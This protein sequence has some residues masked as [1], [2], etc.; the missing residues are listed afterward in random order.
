MKKH[1]L[2]III[3][4]IKLTVNSQTIEITGSIADSSSK[5]LLS[6]GNVI[7]KNKADSVIR[8]SLTNENGEFKIKNIKYQEGQYLLVKY[9]GFTD[10]KVEINYTNNSKINI[11][12]IFIQPDINMMK[13]AVVIDKAKYMEQQFDRKV[14]NIN[15]AKTTSAKNIFDLLRTLPGVTVELNDNVK[16][17]GAPATI[18]VDDQPAEYVY[19]KTEMIPVASVL[20][21]EVIDA[22]LRS[23]EGKGGIINI[24]MKNQTTDGFSGVAQTNNSTIKFNKINESEDYIN[25][26]YKV[27][28]IL[29]YYNAN[30]NHS[31]SYS[32][33]KTDGTLS[34]GSN[35]YQLNDES[36]NES[37]SDALWNYGGFRISPNANTRFRL[38]GGFYKNKGT[39]LSNGNSQ[40]INTGTNTI[41]DKYNAN[42]E[43]TNN[44][45]SK[46][47]NASF[48]HRIDTIGKEIS[49]YGGLQ[50]QGN[51]NKSF[52]TY[53][54]EMPVVSSENYKTENDWGQL[55][56]YGGLFHNHPINAK[57][58]WNF[59]WN[60][61]FQLRGNTDDVY[62]QNDVINYPKTSYTDGKVQRQTLSWRIGTT[63]KKWKFDAGISAQY[64]KN[65][66]EFT[67]FKINSED[68]L[69][70]VTQ[71]G[72]HALPS[73]TIVFSADSLNEIKFT[74]S[75]SIQSVWYN[76]LCDFIDKQNP[77]NWSAGN[78]ELKPTAYNNLFLG[79]TY[80]KQKWNFNA[81]IF[82]SVT[83][84]DVSYL[85]VPYNDIISITTPANISHNSSLGIELSS[86]VSIKQK[87]DLNFS[88]SI[89]QTYIETS[90]LADNGLKKKDFGFNAK[91]SSDFFFNEKTSATFYINYFSREITFEGYN[92]DY[93]NSSVSLTRK[94]FESK[95]LLTLGVNNVFDDFLKHGRYLNYSGFVQ[96][97]IENSSSYKPTYFITLQYKFRQGD[98]GTKDSG[99]QMQ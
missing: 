23:G 5:Q 76:Q 99:K 82:Y 17:K 27:K 64:N 91:F 29:F 93:I 55:G 42:S 74:Y 81:D 20:K 38:T 85:T 86:W 45:I 54:Y 33:S 94:F 13:E 71:D 39:Y 57:T 32:D 3:L 80:N 12:K 26:N 6:F 18:Y 56:F 48:Y 69:L 4:I 98:R 73:A 44:S 75:R 70:K 92:F 41:S 95:F 10:K 77:R 34:F 35:N 62:T 68:T 8:G 88:S 14:F 21:I 16:Y 83:N 28:K 90:D 59:G 87:C 49:I 61:W 84:N 89:K 52:H 30:Y 79:Y 37:N 96:N 9:L 7:L 1:V 97:T 19:P 63:L 40:R 65:V 25:A 53:N 51:V 43:Y 2:L 31:N 78:S 15:A 47:V 50:N 11:G 24:K 58:R 72:I 46:W 60:G 67:R 36:G 22:S 66:A